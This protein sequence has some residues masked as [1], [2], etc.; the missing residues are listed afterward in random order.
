LCRGGGALRIAYGIACGGAVVLI[1][2]QRILAGHAAHLTERVV[3][4]DGMLRMAWELLKLYTATVG[5]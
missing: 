3:L 1:P 4:R 2:I 5:V